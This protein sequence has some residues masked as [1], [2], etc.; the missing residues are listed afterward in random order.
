MTTI[1]RFLTILALSSLPIA[2]KSLYSL[3]LPPKLINNE[4]KSL[5]LTSPI[6]FLVVGS[7]TKLK[8]DLR[9]S[10]IILQ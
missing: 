6:F 9:Y 10:Q 1:D 2:I 4:F 8:K 5:L 3:T 7:E